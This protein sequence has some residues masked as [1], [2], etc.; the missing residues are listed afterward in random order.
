MRNCLSFPQVP[1]PPRKSPFL[2][3]QNVLTAPPP[4]SRESRRREGGGRGGQARLGVG[5]WRPGPG[6]RQEIPGCNSR[7]PSGPPIQ[8]TCCKLLCGFR[9]VAFFTYHPLSSWP[10]PPSPPASGLQLRERETHPDLENLVDFPVLEGTPTKFLEL[11]PAS[12]L[13]SLAVVCTV[14]LWVGSCWVWQAGAQMPSYGS[15]AFNRLGQSL[16]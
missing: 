2:G 9:V 4:T 7:L 1:P 3:S 13:R 11:I 15:Q 16:E 14:W 12:F 5:L 10:W 6:T 8:V